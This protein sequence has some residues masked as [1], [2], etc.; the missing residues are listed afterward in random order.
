MCITSVSL[1]PSY[2]NQRP[3][4][5]TLS[6]SL[7]WILMVWVNFLPPFLSLLDIY[8]HQEDISKL[9]DIT[10]PFT[11]GTPVKS[12]FTVVQILWF[13]LSCPILGMAW[14][15]ANFV[16]DVTQK[17]FEE[18]MVVIMSILGVVNIVFVFLMV[19]LIRK[20]RVRHQHLFGEIQEQSYD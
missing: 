11:P 13:A 4:V 16:D 10:I 5:Q 17:L 9:H 20:K 15:G 8:L 2:I 3:D 1:D 7:A 19:V 12:F 6:L 14:A 18:K